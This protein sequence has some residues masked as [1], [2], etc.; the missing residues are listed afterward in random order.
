MRGIMFDAVVLAYPLLAPDLAGLSRKKRMARF[1][2]ARF[3]A[4]NPK[5]GPS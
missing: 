1:G 4:P 3:T 5:G 2:A